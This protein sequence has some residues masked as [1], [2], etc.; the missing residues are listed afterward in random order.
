MPNKHMKPDSASRTIFGE[1]H[2]AKRAQLAP[3]LMR[4]V[5]QQG[6]K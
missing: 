2:G 4:S 3:L 5:R 6:G 1:T